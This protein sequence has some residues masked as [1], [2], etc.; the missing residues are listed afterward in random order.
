MRIMIT[1][2]GSCFQW[3]KDRNL[4]RC[5]SFLDER[6]E[7]LLSEERHECSFIFS[8][9]VTYETFIK[10]SLAE[11]DFQPSTE[12]CLWCP[13]NRVLPAEPYQQ[14]P[15]QRSLTLVRQFSDFLING[16]DSYLRS[17][18][19]GA[20]PAEF[21]QQS[22][23]SRVPPVEPHLVRQFSD[24]PIDGVRFLPAEPHQQSSTSRFRLASYTFW[25]KTIPKKVTMESVL[26]RIL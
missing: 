1:L 9:D 14:R 13:T 11:K 22:H 26:Y 4:N 24:F 17:L 20:L 10:T 5:S 18:T 7:Q 12:S 16:V 15:T 25:S 23:I 19:I 21:Y 8:T 2:P 3:F 6:C